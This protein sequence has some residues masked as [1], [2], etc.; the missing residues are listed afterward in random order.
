[1]DKSRIKTEFKVHSEHA[2]VNDDPTMSPCNYLGSPFINNCG[3]DLVGE[4]L[5][6]ILFTPNNI[7]LNKRTAAVNGS[8]IEFNQTY[9]LPAIVEP[10]I[11]PQTVGLAHWG[12]VYIPKVCY[13][14]ECHLHI[15]IHGCESNSEWT[16][17]DFFTKLGLNEYAETNNMIILYP[18]AHSIPEPINPYS[19]WDWWGYTGPSYASNVGLQT[20][21]IHNMIWALMN[22]N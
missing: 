21:T 11:D 13:T 19:C 6:H 8:L 2:W 3:R 1:M 15:A 18:Q 20:R 16:G 17:N 10:I 7:T 5:S 12:M 4:F 9:Y 22:A 14:Q